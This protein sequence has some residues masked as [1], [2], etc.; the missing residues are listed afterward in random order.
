[1]LLQR[2]KGILGPDSV[3]VVALPNVVWWRQRLQ[4][5]IGKW[6]YQDWGILDRTHFRFFDKRSSI[7]LLEDAGYEIIRCKNDGPFPL[8]K[9]IRRLIGLRAERIDSFMSELLP[10]LLAAQF[11]YLARVRK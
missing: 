1:M 9:P 4:F 7:E 3:I 5:L 6:R 8:L 11:V 10:G 2:L